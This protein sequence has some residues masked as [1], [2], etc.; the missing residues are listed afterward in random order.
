[1]SP[2]NGTLLRSTVPPKGSAADPA[3]GGYRVARP[4][5][6]QTGP[7]REQSQPDKAAVDV[8]GSLAVPKSCF[9]FLFFSWSVSQL[10]VENLHGNT[11]WMLFAIVKPLPES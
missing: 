4:P 9:G 1:M 6:I 7:G 5:H 3:A 10:P 8:M 11:V 2:S